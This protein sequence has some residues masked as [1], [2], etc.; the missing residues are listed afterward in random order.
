VIPA[1]GFLRKIPPFEIGPRPGLRNGFLQATVDRGREAVLTTAKWAGVAA[2]FGAL[3]GALASELGRAEL[4]DT[5]GV[6]R[7][8]GHAGVRGAGSLRMDSPADRRRP[9][10]AG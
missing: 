2:A 6:W 8:L 7:D 4:G 10:H 3:T 9:T 1:G 5:T